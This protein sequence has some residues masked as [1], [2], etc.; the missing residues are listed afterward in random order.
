MQAPQLNMYKEGSNPKQEKQIYM[1]DLH[2]CKSWKKS[3]Y[4]WKIY[5]KSMTHSDMIHSHSLL[6]P[7]QEIML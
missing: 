4:K 2:H 3:V 6:T 7:I 5:V 1:S